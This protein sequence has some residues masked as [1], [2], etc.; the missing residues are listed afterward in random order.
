MEKVWPRSKDWL[1]LC[2]VKRVDYHGGKNEENNRK[3][4]NKKANK[5]EVLRPSNNIVK[6]FANAF[7]ALN[8]VV[9]ACYCYELA[10]DCVTKIKN[11]SRSYLDL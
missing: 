6:K 2:N 5:S 7:K 1:K 8:D 3:A 10:A 9:A 11:F 4:L